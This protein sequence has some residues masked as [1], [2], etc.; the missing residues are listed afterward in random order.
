ML[1]RLVLSA[2][3]VAGASGMAGAATYPTFVIDAANSSVQITS[4]SGSCVGG[5]CLSVELFPTLAGSSFTPTAVGDSLRIPFIRWTLGS[6][7]AADFTYNIVAT[8]AFSAPDA[9]SATN[10]G[11]GTGVVLSGTIVGGTLVWDDASVPVQF[12]QGSILDV[13]FQGGTLNRER[14]TVTTRALLTA[15]ALVPVPLPA[16]APLLAGALGLLGLAGLRRR[17]RAA[18]PAG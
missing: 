11:G 2:V 1:K 17:R 3:V 6:D 12:A 13:A 8:L 16:A 15:T 10:V 5:P 7:A 18:D 9:A 4:Q 14:R